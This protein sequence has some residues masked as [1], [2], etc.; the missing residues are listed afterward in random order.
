MHR[1][2]TSKETDPKFGGPI[3]WNFEKFLIGRNGEIVQRFKP[4]TKP[5]S[6][7]VTGAIVEELHKK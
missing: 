3:T 1:S 7:E 4:K 5:E 2:V 6:K